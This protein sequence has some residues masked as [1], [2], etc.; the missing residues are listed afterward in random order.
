LSSS[1]S[2]PRF[3]FCVVTFSCTHSIKFIEINKK[4]INLR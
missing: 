3:I 1:S 4:N 2:K